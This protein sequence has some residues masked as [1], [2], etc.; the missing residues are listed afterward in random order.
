MDNEYYLVSP[1]VAA[2]ID[3][4]APV[5]ALESTIIS[6]GMPYPENL[7]TART[8]EQDIRENGAQPATIAIIRGQYRIGLTE[9]ELESLAREGAVKAS[10]RDL[11]SVFANRQTAAT[12]VAT[13]M[14]GAGWAGI[15]VFATGG[16][17]GV[18]RGAE[19]TMDIS[20]DLHELARTPVAVVSAGVKSILDIPRTLEYLETLGVPVLGF[21]TSE[22]PAFFTRESGCQ[23]T[24][25]VRDA[26][27]AA[28]VLAAHWKAGLSGGL[29]IAN[30]IPEPESMDRSEVEGFVGQALADAEKAGVSGKDLTP[31]L[32]ERMVERS[33]GRS[34]TANIALVR[35]NARVAAQIA[36]EY[37]RQAGSKP[38]RG[39]RPHRDA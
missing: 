12:T 21:G 9:P 15:P 37:T 16:T 8:L 35:N 33:G 36:V 3:A 25:S 39:F 14:I 19:H 32:L 5:V 23:L 4:G 20:A 26:R 2:A 27:E 18:H 1:D 10:R 6:H 24:L 22:F 7:E 31:Y 34:L 28:A 11:G 17:G 38:V 13:T 29:L 30:P